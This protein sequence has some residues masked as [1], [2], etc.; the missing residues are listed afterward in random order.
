M[1]IKWLE[2]ELEAA[3][4]QARQ[5]EQARKDLQVE[6]DKVERRQREAVERF[7]DELGDAV[8]SAL[9]ELGFADL[10]ATPAR[11]LERLDEARA[12]ARAA[13]LATAVV[14][15]PGMGRR[16]ALL[17]AAVLVPP[18]VGLIIHLAPLPLAT[19]RDLVA[20]VAGILAPVGAVAAWLRAQFQRLDRWRVLL[21]RPM[22]DEEQELRRR[23]EELDS[24][25]T[26][27][28]RRLELLQARLTKAGDR[29]QA[30]QQRLDDREATIQSGSPAALL[31]R[32]IGDRAESDY[33]RRYLGLLALVR[34]DLE[35]LSDFVERD[36]ERLET[37]A[38]DPPETPEHDRRRVNRIVLY[39]DDLDRCPPKVVVRVLEAIHLLLSFPLF[40][41]VV[42]V[43]VRWASRA[44]ALEYPDL[45][46]DRQQAGGPAT[47]S[48]MDYMEKIVQVPYWVE[49]LEPVRTRQMLEALLGAR[50]GVE[51][52]DEA[53]TP[54]P[55][56]PSGASSNGGPG[57]GPAPL[58]PAQASRPS[59]PP[60]DLSPR[61]MELT[62]PELAC[63][64]TLA[65]LLVRS[66]RALKRFLNIYRLIRTRSY[67][68][69]FAEDRGPASDFRVAML[70][71]AVAT[72]DP[73]AAC[74][75]FGAML[76]PTVAQP[77][78]GDLVTDLTTP[79]PCLGPLHRWLA[80]P[81]NWRWSRL[82]TAVLQPWAREVIRYSFVSRER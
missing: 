73:A 27:V 64:E 45:L 23:G 18:A 33:Y 34:R 6:L 39:I 17:L 58:I 37:K 59:G 1:E 7:R 13:T 56:A 52:R 75:L 9:D 44:L 48:P 65:P 76:A 28:R 19:V 72:G 31:A 25:E 4:R 40:V 54:T 61:R 77:L 41:V 24:E 70:L 57:T 43:D 60:E 2:E 81:S 68:D 42:G 32:L 29:A 12:V 16:L 36:R 74:E 47:A 79:A 20:T 11:A 26:T 55:A 5:V 46:L 82:E 22:P 38:P 50:L 71:L 49:P 35:A 21:T 51:S 66:P 78:L 69:G 62:Q 63:M 30:A 80:A 3:T 67:W 53:Q 8:S 15:A 10:G 14:R